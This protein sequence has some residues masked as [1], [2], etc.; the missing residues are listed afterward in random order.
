MKII[1]LG[2]GSAFCKKNWQT[3]Y[4]IE[5]GG[6]MLVDCGGDVRWSLNDQ[7]L[8]YL[9]IDAVYISHA[10]ADHC[11]GV[12]WLAYGTYFDPRYSGKPKFFA[13]RQLLVDLWNH[14]LRGGLEG[15]QGVDAT[16]ETYFD[17]PVIMARGNFTWNGIVFSLVQSI[18]V[19]AKYTLVSSYGLMFTDPD[20]NKRIYITTDVQFAPETSMKAF[21]KEANLII[22]DCETAPY[23]SGVHAHYNQLRELPAVIKGKMLL[24]HYQDNVNEDPEAWDSKA[25]SDGFLGFAKVG[26]IYESERE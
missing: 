15:L 21:Y 2:T 14:T 22:H 23:M 1:A 11:G 25:S 17:A 10:H 3:N 8:D 24:S 12:E 13:E 16:L 26:T 20:N 18:H 4:L 7:G 19:T 9:D 6:R 5:R